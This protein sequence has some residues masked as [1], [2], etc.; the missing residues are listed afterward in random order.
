MELSALRDLLSLLSTYNVTHYKDESIELNL[1]SPNQEKG[2]SPTLNSKRP[3]STQD[4]EIVDEAPPGPPKTLFPTAL[5]MSEEDF[6]YYS[7]DYDPKEQLKAEEQ[8]K[9]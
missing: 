5:P 2:V 4:T 6:L 1:A 9:Q 8:I 7:T 3:E